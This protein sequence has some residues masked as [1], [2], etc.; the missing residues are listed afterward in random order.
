MNI[1]VIAGIL[2]ALLLVL[3]AVRRIDWSQ[4]TVRKLGAAP[5][6]LIAV[7]LSVAIIAA[8]LLE[9]VK[10]GVAFVVV[11]VLTLAAGY[12]ACRDYVLG[13]LMRAGGRVRRG[14]VVIVDGH[15]GVV[16]EVGR[17]N[18]TLDDPRG[19]LLVPYSKL[20]R[21]VVH[22]RSQRV[23][24][25]PHRFDVE[26][27]DARSHPEVARVVK[28]TILLHPRAA[29][30]RDPEVEPTAPR[31]VSVTVYTVSNA[32]GFEVERAVREAL[33]EVDSPGPRLPLPPP[34]S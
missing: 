11:V 28:R 8:A 20:A 34:S 24:P 3:I 6:E 21:S 10:F 4:R 15:E 5:L 17:L 18:L 26:W 7:V 33:G 23:G 27:R 22:R 2:L 9:S 12:D 1:E 19:R 16:A 31:R 32:H 13:V 25:L 29:A 30:G 14:D